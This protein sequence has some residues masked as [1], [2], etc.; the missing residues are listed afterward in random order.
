LSEPGSSTR[1]PN[2]ADSKTDEERE[3]KEAKRNEERWAKEAKKAAKAAEKAEKANL[4]VAATQ[5]LFDD[6]EL[7]AK[8]SE[9]TVVG[10]RK[11]YNRFDTDHSGQ[12][13]LQELTNMFSYLWQR[14]NKKKMHEIMVRFGT[15]AKDGE[16]LKKNV[17]KETMSFEEFIVFVAHSSEYMTRNISTRV[18]GAKLIDQPFSYIVERIMRVVYLPTFV[19]GCIVMFSL[20]SRYN[21]AVS[22]IDV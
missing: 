10:L 9:N 16:V 5:V 14:P 15:Q 8:I 4:K 19:V 7:S 1:L 17:H 2:I 11:I 22:V 6:P 13:S 20:S 18:D 21:A 12:I 3:A